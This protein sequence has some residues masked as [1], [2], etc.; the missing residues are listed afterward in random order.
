MNLN[1]SRGKFEMMLTQMV[2]DA[3]GKKGEWIAGK[4][5]G[6]EPKFFIVGDEPVDKDYITK[7]PFS[8]AL[9]EVLVAV[10]RTLRK[11]YPGT[12][13]DHCHVTYMVKTTYKV[14]E[15][16]ED[17]IIKK[18]LPIIQLEYHLSGCDLVVAVG[19]MARVF[20]GAIAN[21]PVCLSEYKPSFGERIRGAW[22][23]LR[24]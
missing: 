17:D 4:S 12:T 19:R 15:L 18:W 8:G 23:R 24:G 3:C 10:I 11:R 6:K 20:A 21:K 2:K 16:T 13:R 7:V 5:L 14:N 1:G 22:D 9:G